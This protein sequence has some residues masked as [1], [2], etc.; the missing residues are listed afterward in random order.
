VCPTSYVSELFVCLFRSGYYLAGRDGA[1]LAPISHLWTEHALHV[2]VAGTKVLIR[3]ECREKNRTA[4]RARPRRCC[5]GRGR[6]IAGRASGRARLAR[7]SPLLSTKWTARNRNCLDEGPA[8]Q[9]VPRYL[10]ANV[11]SGKANQLN[12]TGPSSHRVLMPHQ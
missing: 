12:T 11:D 8:R 10:M 3:S 1:H 2:L 6:S 7:S 5:T 4:G 9:I